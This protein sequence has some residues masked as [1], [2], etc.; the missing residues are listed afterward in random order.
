MNF[1]KEAWSCDSMQY[2]LSLVLSVI[3]QW[4]TIVPKCGD[5]GWSILVL[6]AALFGDIGV[7]ISVS[8]SKLK[9]PIQLTSYKSYQVT[10][11]ICYNLHCVQLTTSYF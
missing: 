5:L 2:Q 1:L 10:Q 4:W 7:R 6:T 9:F 8:V 3:V 11:V